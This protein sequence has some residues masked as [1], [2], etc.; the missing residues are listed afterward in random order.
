[1]SSILFGKLPLKKY[2][3]K[4]LVTAEVED[5]NEWYCFYKLKN[6]KRTI[7]NMNLMIIF[8]HGH[9]YEFKYHYMNFI[10]K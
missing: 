3:K 7:E 2:I 4:V 8:C 9:T 1:M 5:P 6:K 10:I